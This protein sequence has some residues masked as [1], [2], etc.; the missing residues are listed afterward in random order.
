MTTGMFSVL[1]AYSF[2]FPLIS[3][4]TSIQSSNLKDVKVYAND[5]CPCCFSITDSIT[6]NNA[7]ILKLQI[8][9]PGTYNP[10]DLHLGLIQ[11]AKLGN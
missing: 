8:S 9:T 7:F 2:R 1:Y 6:N 4:L 11:A 3:Y 10:R 5:T